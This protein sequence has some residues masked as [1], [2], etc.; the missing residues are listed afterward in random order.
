MRVCTTAMGNDND[1]PVAAAARRRRQRAGG[2][3]DAKRARTR[4][5]D[6]ASAARSDGRQAAQ[7]QQPPHGRGGSCVRAVRLA[8][9]EPRSVRVQHEAL[10][11]Q[12][13][14]RMPRRA[15]ETS[16]LC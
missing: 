10:A 3:R 8:G 6:G 4:I 15:A 11:A 14:R 7:R 13:A 5:D 1:A 16:L 9:A 12:A 2:G